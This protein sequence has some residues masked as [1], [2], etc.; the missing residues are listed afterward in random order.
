[1]LAIKCAYVQTAVTT[2]QRH[3]LDVS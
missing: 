3:G 2:E 1:M